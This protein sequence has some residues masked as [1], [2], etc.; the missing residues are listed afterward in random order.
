MLLVGGCIGYVSDM[1]RIMEDVVAFKPTYFAGVPRI[2]E[3][4][5]SGVMGKVGCA[6]F[7]VACCFCFGIVVCAVH[8]CPMAFAESI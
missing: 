3:R 8:G 2:Y 5:Y 7:G 1:R 4:V 6:W